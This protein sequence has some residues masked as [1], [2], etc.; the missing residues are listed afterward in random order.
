MWGWQADIKGSK[1]ALILLFYQGFGLGVAY[2]TA[3]RS[4]STSTTCA[5]INLEILGLL[6][7]RLLKY[8]CAYSLISTQLSLLQLE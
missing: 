2:A 1:C 4:L 6:K 5:V 7:S 8:S 3:A